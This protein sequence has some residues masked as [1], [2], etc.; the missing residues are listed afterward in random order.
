MQALTIMESNVPHYLI[1]ALTKIK[2]SRLYK[3]RD[4]AIR[5][6]YNPNILKLLLN[7]YVVDKRKPGRPLVLTLNIVQIIKDIVT[8]N[9]I[10]RS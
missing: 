3:I 4:K 2:T 9:L 7:D 8:K 6:G 1:T 10:T 5:R